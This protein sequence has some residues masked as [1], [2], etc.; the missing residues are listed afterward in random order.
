HGMRLETTL[1]TRWQLR[2]APSSPLP[3]LDPPGEVL[4][5]DLID[6]LPA[7][8]DGRRWR[9]LLNEA[10]VLLHQHP[11]NRARARQGKSTANSLWFW[12]AGALPQTVRSDLRHVYADDVLP[13]ALAARAHLRTDPLADFDPER[14]VAADTLL[15]LGQEDAAAAMRQVLRP[16]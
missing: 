12:G 13:V 10:Q 16:L 15:D 8:D 7:G 9:Q 1:P 5:D 3:P 2:L 11:V 6:H 14:P 4:G